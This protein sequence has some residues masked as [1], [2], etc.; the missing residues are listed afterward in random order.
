MI[1]KLEQATLSYII[2]FYKSMLLLFDNWKDSEFIDI[3]K[4]R[5]ELYAKYQE[6]NT[7]QGTLQSYMSTNASYE[8]L[9]RNST[10]QKALQKYLN[11]KN[12]G[13]LSSFPSYLSDEI[14][15]GQIR[16]SLQFILSRKKSKKSSLHRQ[17]FHKKGKVS[18]KAEGAFTWGWVDSYLLLDG[19]NLSYYSTTSEKKVPL[20]IVSVIGAKVEK[21]DDPKILFGVRV[22]PSDASIP[23]EFKPGNEDDNEEWFNILKAASNIDHHDFEEEEAVLECLEDEGEQDLGNRMSR[24]LRKEI[25]ETR[26]LLAKKEWYLETSENGVRLYGQRNNEYTRERDRVLNERLKWTLTKIYGNQSEN[27]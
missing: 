14:E 18:K 22:S 11:A 3:R 4:R 8:D 23:I 26:K 16:T 13:S 20:R 1:E 19:T 15:P 7:S 21:I 12:R 25:S 6:K 5:A 27:P 9:V 10:I 2:Y 17:L 24:S